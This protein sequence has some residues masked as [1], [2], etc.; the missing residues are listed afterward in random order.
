M[1][2]HGIAQHPASHLHKTTEQPKQ[3]LI[4]QEVDIDLMVGLKV[5]AVH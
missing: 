3:F 1:E 2:E 4:Q 5:V